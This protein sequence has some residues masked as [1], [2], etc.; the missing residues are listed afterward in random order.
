MINLPE[1]TSQWFN[2]TLTI[3]TT[4]GSQTFSEKF[5][6]EFEDPYS[7]FEGESFDGDDYYTDTKLRFSSLEKGT[8]RVVLVE[9]GKTF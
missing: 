5:F 8:H 6:V 9:D 2:K 1:N 3:E 4:H 7:H